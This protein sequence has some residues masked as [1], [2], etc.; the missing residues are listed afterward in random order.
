[1][2]EA[3][4]TPFPLWSTFSG[5]FEAAPIR[6]SRGASCGMPFCVR[7]QN[8]QRCT[9]SKILGSH[10]RWKSKHAD[11]VREWLVRQTPSSAFRVIRLGAFHSKADSEHG[12]LPSTRV[13]DVS[14][15][16]SEELFDQKMVGSWD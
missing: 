12:D 2:R 7:D 13:I 10:G 15:M 6:F 8:C 5:K 3:Q 1:M 11:A 16:D 14:H 4:S 9:W